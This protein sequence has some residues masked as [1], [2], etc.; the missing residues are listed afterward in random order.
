M[1]MHASR[2][3]KANLHKKMW[4][5]NFE[6]SGYSQIGVDLARGE[7]EYVTSLYDVLEIQKQDRIVVKHQLQELFWK[8]Q[9]VPSYAEAVIDYYSAS[10]DSGT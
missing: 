5:K 10:W 1:P 9:D 8:H 2:A 6:L 7:G 3:E 4:A